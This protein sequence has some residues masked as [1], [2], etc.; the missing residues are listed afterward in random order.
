MRFTY[1]SHDDFWR[2]TCGIVADTHGFD[3]MAREC[4]IDTLGRAHPTQQADALDAILVRFPVNDPADPQRPN[5]RMPNLELVIREWIDRLRDTAGQI[6]ISL[7]TASREVH[8]ALADAEQLGA[9]RSVDR[10][11]T[12]MHSYLHQVCA[13]KNLTVAGDTPTMAKLLK[14]I[15]QHHPAPADLGPLE[16]EITRVLQAMGTILD[17]LN[18]IR[19]RGSA[20]HPRNEVLDEPEAELVCNSVRTLLGYLE[21]R[22]NS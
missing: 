12:A 13:D 17:A 2:E 21:A 19:N 6:V 14:E 15:R 4:F 11:H 1:A 9:R 5:L 16:S 7:A 8:A 10:G 18:P 20:A 22:L 3:G